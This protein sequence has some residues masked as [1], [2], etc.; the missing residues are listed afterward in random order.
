MGVKKGALALGGNTGVSA[1][2]YAQEIKG[3]TCPCCG[4]SDLQTETRFGSGKKKLYLD[5]VPKHRDPRDKRRL[6]KGSGKSRRL[7]C[8]KCNRRVPSHYSVDQYGNSAT[9]LVP[10]NNGHGEACSGG[11]AGE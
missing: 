2:Q 4:R 11:T 10:H 1:P 8:Q 3:V 7:K 9:L 5:V 6:C